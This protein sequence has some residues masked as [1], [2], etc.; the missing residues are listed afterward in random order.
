MI[1]DVHSPH[2]NPEEV[3]KRLEQLA[4]RQVERPL[5][6]D[7]HQQ[8][9]VDHLILQLLAYHLGPRSRAVQA[10]NALFRRYMSGNLR[11]MPPQPADRRAI[12]D[13]NAR[14]PSPS[15][16]RSLHVDRPSQAPGYTQVA[17]ERIEYCVRA[18]ISQHLLA[19]HNGR[20]HLKMVIDHA[21]GDLITTLTAGIWGET[22]DA[23]EREYSWPANWKE[24]FKE[25]W[26][27]GWMRKCWPTQRT[28]KHFTVKAL[29]PGFQPQVKGMDYRL[30]IMGG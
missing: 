8:Y 13:P 4:Q 11:R 18:A 28:K 22:S 6:F 9:E 17:L 26:F 15:E 3:E 1:Y 2:F 24:A 10:V 20:N 25:H 14:A 12:F 30:V 19:G 23:T 16:S 29:Y 7:E 27:K 21:T 5:D